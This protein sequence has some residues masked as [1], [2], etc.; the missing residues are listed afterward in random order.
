M[1]KENGRGQGRE[2]ERGVKD[3]DWRERMGGGGIKG[4]KEGK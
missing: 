1:K 3:N 4:P 2:G